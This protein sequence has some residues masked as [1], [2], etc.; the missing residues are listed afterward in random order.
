MVDNIEKYD[1]R[2]IFNRIFDINDGNRRNDF[3][4]GGGREPLH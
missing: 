1:R 4:D 3:K 2:G